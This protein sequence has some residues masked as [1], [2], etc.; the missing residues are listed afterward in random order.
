MVIRS[1]DMWIRILVIFVHRFLLLLIDLST[2]YPDFIH[3][4]CI[5]IQC[6]TLI[7][8]LLWIKSV[9]YLV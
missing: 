7:S 5:E 8:V 6:L 2:A 4:E 3:N 9:D 1:V